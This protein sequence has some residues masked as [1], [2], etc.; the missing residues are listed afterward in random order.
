VSAYD[1]DPHTLVI[2]STPHTFPKAV[3]GHQAL[4]V[5]DSWYEERSQHP[6]NLKAPASYPVIAVCKRCHGR[7][8]L[9]G[10]LQMEW[11]HVPDAAPSPEAPPS[12]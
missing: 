12:L 2:P 7:I 3:D 8:R 11:T 1:F 4:P 10:P 6:A 5:K 9:S